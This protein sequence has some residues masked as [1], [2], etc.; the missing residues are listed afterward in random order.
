MPEAAMRG[1]HADAQASA[2]AS[3]YNAKCMGDDPSELPPTG[4]AAGSSAGSDHKPPK[5]G[6]SASARH[7]DASVLGNERNNLYSMLS[8]TMSSRIFVVRKCG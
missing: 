3:A 4:P 2:A 7:I 5:K 8:R 1:R 6:D